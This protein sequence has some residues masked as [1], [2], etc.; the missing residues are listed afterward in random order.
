QGASLWL[1]RFK[2]LTTQGDRITGASYVDVNA[3]IPGQTILAIAAVIVAVLFFVTAVI[4]RWR[5]PLIGTALLVV[6]SIVVGIAYPWV[7]TQFQVVP[8]QRTLEAPYYERNLEATKTAYG[9]DGLKKTDFEAV[10]DVEAGQL[11]ADAATT[12]SIR[13]M[14]PAIIGPTLRQLDQ[15]RGYYQFTDP[16]D[17][18]RDPIDGESQDTV[19]SVRE[20]DMNQLGQAACWY[21]TTLVY[22]R[23]YGMVAAKG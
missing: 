18:D 19:V 22:T 12:A 10:T 13:I 23:G 15:C 5:F 16:M 4:G 14:D 8:N 6:S 1:D 20:L 17:V 2:T 21:N 7:V 3:I 11:R 9:I